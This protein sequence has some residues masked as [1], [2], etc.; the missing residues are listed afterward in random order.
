V[1]GP[2]KNGFVNVVG[3]GRDEAEFKAA[4]Q[5]ACAS[6]GLEVQDLAEIEPFVHRFSGTT[7]PDDVAAARDQVTATTRA[8][9]TTLFTYDVD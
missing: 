5:S 4:V 2:G 8:V 6:L 1:L 7:V 3:Q 9:L